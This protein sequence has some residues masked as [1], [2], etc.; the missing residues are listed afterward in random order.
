MLKINGNQDKELAF[1]VEIGGASPDSIV[2]RLRLVLDE[3]EYGF[4][5]K[6]TS[7]AIIVEMPALKKIFHRKV[8]EGE[9]VQA[10]LDLT[11]DGNVVSPWTEVLEITDFAVSEAKLTDGVTKNKV[12]TLKETEEPT[13]DAREKAKELIERVESKT[14]L[15]SD[16]SVDLETKIRKR[17]EENKDNKVENK[18]SELSG[19]DA[20]VEMSSKIIDK[21]NEKLFGGKKTKREKQLEKL[22]EQVDITVA[23]KNAKS[24]FSPR[25]AANTKGITLEMIK[26]FTR[27]DV[28]AYM[29]RAGTTNSRVQ[30]IL[31]EQA[32]VASKSDVPVKILKEVIKIIKKNKR[33]N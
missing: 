26:N 4:P 11:S 6:V 14:R 12:K 22:T 1:E 19:A 9:A 25:R 8:K 5:A 17:L 24:A 29:S 28:F 31:Y 13:M 23:R 32:T 21:L 16:D 20:D 2:A 33:R 27:E 10:R 7:S 3:I 18:Y 30:E 15:D